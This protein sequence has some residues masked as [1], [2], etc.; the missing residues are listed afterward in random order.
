MET[1]EKEVLPHLSTSKKICFIGHSLGNLFI[2]H[3]L[4]KHKIKL[5][6]AIFVCPC[7]DRLGLVP[8]QYDM[9]NTSFYKTDFDFAML[10]KQ[11][12]T[13]YVLYSDT[14][15]YI[16]PRRALHFA[17]VLESSPIMVKR[18][19]HLNSGVNLNEFPLVFDLCTTRLDLNLYQ[20]FVL[21]RTKDSIAKNI[22]DSTNKFLIISPDEGRDE[23]R[24]HFMNIS[25]SGF[26][27]FPSNAENWDPC[28]MY[29]TDGRTAARR[30]VN[31][32][33]T[34]IVKNTKDLERKVLQKQIEL[35]LKSGIQVHLIEN[36]IYISLGAE[37]DFGIWDDEYVCIIKRD[38]NGKQLE[39][40]LD[41]RTES[42]VKAQAWREQILKNS[43]EIKSLK[44]FQSWKSH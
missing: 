41:S 20:H 34:F 11:A 22:I 31:I 25:K 38:K 21:S 23:G 33:R 14:D 6:C 39:L 5:D 35:D 29:F 28:D 36:K 43:T 10:V 7:L 40:L 17:K 18:A 32:I 27:T 44:E 3:V 16:E 24:F 12:P 2:L 13:S 42:I 1:F 30:G 8:W 15:P 9:V 37:E 19:G 26:G 4:S